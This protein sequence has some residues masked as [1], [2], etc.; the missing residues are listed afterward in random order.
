MTRAPGLTSAALRHRTTS[1]AVPVSLERTRADC[2]ATGCT[3]FDRFPDIRRG[4]SVW[5]LNSAF[6]V[7][8]ICRE[9]YCWINVLQ[10]D[11]D[12]LVLGTVPLL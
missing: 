5:L 12:M 11:P 10:R 7:G 6:S 9:N 1:V 2:I 8:K 4:G 3:E